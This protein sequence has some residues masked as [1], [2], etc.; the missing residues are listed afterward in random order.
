MR[1]AA[2]HETAHFSGPPDSQ[3]THTGPHSLTAADVLSEHHQLVLPDTGIEV[4]GK[5][6]GREGGGE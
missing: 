2:E 4:A 3:P 6:G 5:G 1:C